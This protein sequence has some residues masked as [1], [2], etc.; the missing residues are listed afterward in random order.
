MNVSLDAVREEEHLIAKNLFRSGASIDSV[1]KSLM[2]LNEMEHMCQVRE[3][4]LSGLTDDPTV[5]EKKLQLWNLTKDVPYVLQTIILIARKGCISSE[6]DTVP[7]NM[8]REIPTALSDAVLDSK[9]ETC[10]KYLLVKHLSETDL[11][12]LEPH[13]LR[14]PNSK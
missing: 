5:T 11:F 7:R 10:A 1:L 4:L 13:E 3:R 8:Y 9:S 12:Q 6:H 14:L 2:S